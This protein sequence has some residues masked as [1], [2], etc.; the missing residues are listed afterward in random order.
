MALSDYSHRAY[1]KNFAQ[2]GL[3]RYY[4]IVHYFKTGGTVQGQGISETKR[5]IPTYYY[6][7][8][9]GSEGGGLCTE[10]QMEQIKNTDGVAMRDRLSNQ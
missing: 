7:R 4:S 5:G 8:K 2:G 9:V 10:N 1:A 6:A 3:V